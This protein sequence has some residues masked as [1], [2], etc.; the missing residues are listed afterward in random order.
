M[1]PISSSEDT[2]VFNLF[3]LYY[4]TAFQ[5]KQLQINPVK[6]RHFRFELFSNRVRFERIRDIFSSEDEVKKKIT[7]MVP[8]N[9]YHTPVRWLSPIYVSKTK[10]EIDVMLSSPL[11]F[12]I[13]IDIPNAK[14]FDSAKK[15]L[16]QLIDYM[17]NRFS[18]KPD[19]VVFSGRKGF[20]IYYWEWDFGK[21]VHLLPQQRIKYFIEDRLKLLSELN[22]AGIKVDQTVTADPYR[23]MKVP[24][25]LHGKTGLIAKPIEDIYRFNPINDCMAFDKVIYSKKFCLNLDFYQC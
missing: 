24:N 1:S 16:I 9:T 23:L 22:E 5:S 17:E 15:V 12:D 25:T 6:F 3:K 7:Q 18:R 4:K 8:R 20:H 21:I 13:D 19:L 14:N 11:Y 10:N 2:S